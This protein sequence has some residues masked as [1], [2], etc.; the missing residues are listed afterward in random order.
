MSSR[1]QPWRH[2][3]SDIVYSLQQ[4]ISPTDYY[5]FLISSK[6]FDEVK[7]RSW[8]IVLREADVVRYVED[9]AFRTRLA[10]RIQNLSKQLFVYYSRDNARHLGYFQEILSI[11]SRGVSIYSSRSN[12]IA[13]YDV[14][15]EKQE[16]ELTS[17]DN[18]TNLSELSF[19]R[20]KSLKLSFIHSMNS[21]PVD[22]GNLLELKLFYCNSITDVSH[23]RTI[24]KVYLRQCNKIQDI[25]PLNRVPFLTLEECSGIEDI[26][27]LTHHLSLTVFRCSYIDPS[28]VNFQDVA[29]LKTDLIQS[30]SSSEKLSSVRSLRSVFYHLS[31]TPDDEIY[32]PSSVKHATIQLFQHKMLSLSSSS[33]AHLRSVHFDSV[34][35]ITNLHCCASIPFVHISVSHLVSIEGLGKNRRVEISHCDSV[36]DFSPLAAVP[37]VIVD[38]CRLFQ[39][40]ADLHQVQYLK[41]SHCH[42]FRDTTP[43]SKNSLLK[44][45]EISSCKKLTRLDGLQ[46][47]PFVSV[48]QCL[49]LKSLR[50][51]GNNQKIILD[52]SAQML[53]P[54]YPNLVAEYRQHYN[55]PWTITLLR[56]P[57]PAISDQ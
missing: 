16:I 49:H 36:R 11:P 15:N 6:V 40:A 14:L 25:S 35:G 31:K 26:S 46:Q 18:I 34:D 7:F 41:I 9:E 55:G 48:I 1:Y 37:S 29:E 28:T 3:P 19:R 2:V 30:F 43:F 23:F 33:F 24:K 5:S 56:N 27:S 20:I 10:T 17:C 44:S 12:S 51:L 50:G 8:R 57:A 32:I 13:W 47:I 42:S 38:N 4:Y 52:K 39:N 21:L 54:H 53:V 22:V 45:L